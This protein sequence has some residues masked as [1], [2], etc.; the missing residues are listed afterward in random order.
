M[1]EEVRRS[2]D[3]AS[4]FYS[5]AYGRRQEDL[6]KLMQQALDQGWMTSAQPASPLAELMLGLWEGCGFV[7][8]LLGLTDQTFPIPMGRANGLLPPF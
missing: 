3:L 1:F 2:P 5:C 6:A 8:A 7:R 4:Y